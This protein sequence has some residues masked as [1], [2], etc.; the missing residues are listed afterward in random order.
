MDILQNADPLLQTFWYIAAPVSVIFIIQ[1]ILT[2]VGGDSMDGVEADFEGDLSEGEAPF[3]LFSLRNLINFLLGF[4]WAGIAFYTLIPN[5]A[6]LI[7]AAVIAGILFVAVFFVIVRVFW[8]LAEDNSFRME[9]AL[10]KT[11]EVYLTIPANRTGRGKILISTGGSLRELEAMTN[12]KEPI[13]SQ[14]TVKIVKIENNNIL[15]VEKI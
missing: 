13:H 3:Q 4:G 5:K 6:L 10:N 1:T 7:I 9:H 14:S 8:R 15:I 11:A 12:E 2:F